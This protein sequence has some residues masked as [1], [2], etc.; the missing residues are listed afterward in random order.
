M[1]PYSPC[2]LNSKSGWF[3][4]RIHGV[5]WGVV[6]PA[7]LFCGTEASAGPRLHNTLKYPGIFDSHETKRQN[8]DFSRALKLR[9]KVQESMCSAS[10]APSGTGYSEAFPLGDLTFWP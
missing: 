5:V 2:R 4:S 7:G 3:S 1:S 8:Q 6:I 10:G 9:E